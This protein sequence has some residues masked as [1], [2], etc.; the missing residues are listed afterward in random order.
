MGDYAR[1][2]RGWL[3]GIVLTI[4][5]F[6]YSGVLWQAFR[7]GERHGKIAGGVVM[8]AASVLTAHD[9]L[10]ND[11]YRTSRIHRVSKVMFFIGL[12]V[13]VVFGHA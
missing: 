10:T 3:Y 9:A 2:P 12:V 13:F 4:F 7:E 8:L 1:P 5:I 11:A 6:W